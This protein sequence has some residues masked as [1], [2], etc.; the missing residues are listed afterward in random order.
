[1]YDKA[2]I[3]VTADVFDQLSS[4]GKSITKK[5]SCNSLLAIVLI[6]GLLHNNLKIYQWVKVA[7]A[8]SLYIVTD[9]CFLYFRAFH[10]DH[11]ITVS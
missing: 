11:D 1:M 5:K 3:S 4:T 2:I 9:A 10:E 7:E 8:A 6:A